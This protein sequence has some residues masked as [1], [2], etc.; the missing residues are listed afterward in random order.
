[1]ECSLVPKKYVKKLKKKYIYK[2]KYLSMNY[3]V[4]KSLKWIRNYMNSLKYNSINNRSLFCYLD[5]IL[6]YKFSYI[7]LKKI[8]VYKKIFKI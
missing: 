6:N 8:S 4:N 1:M 2:I 3:R 7:Y 5:L